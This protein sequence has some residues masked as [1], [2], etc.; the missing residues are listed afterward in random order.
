[1]SRTM[2]L[3]ISICLITIGV[4]TNYDIVVATL[5]VALCAND[6]EILLPILVIGPIC[7]TAFVLFP[8]FTFSALLS[9]FC[10]A[11]ALV[12]LVR[13][14]DFIGVPPMLG[15]FI[16]LGLSFLFNL[17]KA[18]L[19]GFDTATPTQIISITSK[20][21]TVW[22]VYRLATKHTFDWSLFWSN[23]Q[24]IGFATL[25]VVYVHILGNSITYNWYNQ[26][27]R[28]GYYGADLNEFSVCCI[29]L[30][31]MILG[32][33]NVQIFSRLGLACM[34]LVVLL[35][36]KTVSLSATIILCSALILHSFHEKTLRLTLGV[37][38]V[39]A[40]IF[41]SDLLS[42][43]AETSIGVRSAFL[44]EGGTQRDVTTGRLTLWIGA[45]KGI[46]ENFMWG[47]GPGAAT[48]ESFNHSYSGIKLVTHNTVLQFLISFG[49]VGVFNLILTLAVFK[50][51][52]L[53]FSHYALVGSLAI[54][55]A[56][57]MSLSWLW[58]DS[59]WILLGLHLGYNYAKSS[60]NN[61]NFG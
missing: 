55:G 27:E 36:F 59:I 60:A 47:V 22:A 30:V 18:P 23:Q 33:H 42:L 46:G 38:A 26:L 53:S 48:E 28:I 58:K 29:A 1:M 12:V 57:A 21:L 17:S 37:A 50:R 11:K 54:L 19:Q 43:L 8:G 14:H 6:D 2:K 7:E 41:F 16:I 13:R 32:K 24:I 44:S 61:S 20:L 35:I 49:F 34:T 4:Y 25:C 52:V 9:L 40:T 39:G 31:P 5:L 51:Q 10:V 56:G 15:G 45:M 3:A